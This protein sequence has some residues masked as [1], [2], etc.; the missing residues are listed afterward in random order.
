MN[1]LQGTHYCL[2][3]WPD[4]R[5]PGWLFLQ[6]ADS[7]FTDPAG[8]AAKHQAFW[9]TASFLFT[10]TNDSIIP[11]IK[12]LF[13]F[14]VFGIEDGDRLLP[15]RHSFSCL[16][17]L[18]LILL[19]FSDVFQVPGGKEGCQGSCYNSNCGFYLNLRRIR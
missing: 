19:L 9:I 7:Y 11:S 12:H 14:P 16:K 18:G 5:S 6:R 15:P 4:S 10:A 8:Q 1:P 2:P 17:G 3:G 13:F